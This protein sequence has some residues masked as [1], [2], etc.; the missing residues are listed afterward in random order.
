MAEFKAGL[1]ELFLKTIRYIAEMDFLNGSAII[2]NRKLRAFMGMSGM[3]TDKAI[4]AF[5][6]MDEAVRLQEINGAVNSWWFG[7]F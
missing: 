4:Q 2:T 1:F 5:N 7:V 3:T 6:F